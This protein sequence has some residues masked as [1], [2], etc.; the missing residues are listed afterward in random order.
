MK[1]TNFNGK[2]ICAQVVTALVSMV[3][4]TSTAFAA[5]FSNVYVP[6]VELLNSLLGPLLAIVSAVGGLYCVLLGVKYA[7]AEEPQEREKAKTHLKNAIIGFVLIFVLILAMNLMLPIM[8]NWVNKSIIAKG[9]S[10]VF[11]K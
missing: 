2:R 8:K 5:D 11:T 6:I 4:V 3:M 7:K 1:K 9:G 10:A